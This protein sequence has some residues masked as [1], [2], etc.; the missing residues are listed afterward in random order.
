MRSTRGNI[1][2]LILL[3]VVLFAALSYAVTQS[4]RGGGKDAT[5]ESFGA[6]ASQ[7]LQYA[8]LL[9]N[10]FMR[11]MLV[12]DVKDYGFDIS[13][14]NNAWVQNNS[15]TNINCRLFNKSAREGL[16]TSLELPAKYMAS[17]DGRA[18]FRV[19]SVVNIGTSAEDLILLYRSISLP[20]CNA[21]NAQLGINPDLAN[22]EGYGGTITNYS[23]TL[24]AMP[25]SGSIIGN[26]ITSL[27]NQ[28]AG[29]FRHSNDGYV[30]FY[31][32]L[33]R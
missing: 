20:L 29:C 7:L 13:A 18:T 14:D 22:D 27:A 30:F 10:T 17:G 33:A 32:L 16:T 23:G 3:A 4:L 28:K 8:G 1:L 21:I 11:Q 2:F 19:A 31:V 12:A 5:S 15:C 6:Y 25:V 26:D 9:E 24:T